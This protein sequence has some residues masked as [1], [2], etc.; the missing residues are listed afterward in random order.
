MVPLLLPGKARL[1]HFI[2]KQ[3]S[4]DQA[5]AIGATVTRIEII[6]AFF[7]IHPNKAPG[8]DGFNA[9]FYRRVWHIVGE[10]IIHDVHSFFASNY[11]LKISITQLF[12]LYPKEQTLQGLVSIGLRMKWK[13]RMAVPL[14]FHGSCRHCSLGRSGEDPLVL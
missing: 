14:G 2:D 3:I 12:L 9:F 6:E 11:L 10:D 13:G 5:R 4:A 8:P 1:A 7:S